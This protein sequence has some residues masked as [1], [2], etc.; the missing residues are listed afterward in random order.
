MKLER[1]Q[2][3]DMIELIAVVCLVVLFY[4][5]DLYIEVKRKKV[6]EDHSTRA[7]E[8][9]LQMAKA[10]AALAPTAQEATERMKEFAVAFKDAYE[11]EMNKK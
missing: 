6:I 4:L 2:G 7:N 1:K 11:S 3:I 8:L 10:A 9:T 5:V